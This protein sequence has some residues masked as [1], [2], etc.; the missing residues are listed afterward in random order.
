[1]KL[2]TSGVSYVNSAHWAAV[3]DGIA[4]LK[5]HFE[6]E[7]ERLLV[8]CSSEPPKPYLAGPQLLYG[9]PRYATKEEILA[10]IPPRPVVDRLISRYFNALDMAPGQSVQQ[11]LYYVVPTVA[12]EY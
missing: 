7:D 1:M 12:G 6:R 11:M 8:R 4:E 10:A 3:L 9:C 5:D 2:T